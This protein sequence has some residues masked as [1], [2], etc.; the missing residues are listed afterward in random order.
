[1]S[2]KIDYVAC[3]IVAAVGAPGAPR[4]SSGAPPAR[5]PVL[6]S[7]NS[8]NRWTRHAAGIRGT[9]LARRTLMRSM[10][11]RKED[12]DT[13]DCPDRSATGVDWS[14]LLREAATR[15]GVRA[16]RPG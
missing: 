3:K 15:F 10:A 6:R 16:L 5:R 11:A 4:R 14:E 12:V 8:S 2:D 7:G 13:E 1:M 9:A